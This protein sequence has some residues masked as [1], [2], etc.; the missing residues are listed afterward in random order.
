[1][2]FEFH[3]EEGIHDKIVKLYPKI[4]TARCY[5][6]K[7]DTPSVRPAVDTYNVDRDRVIC[8]LIN[9][10][11]TTKEAILVLC[12]SRLGDDAF[13]LARVALENSIVFSWL[14][15]KDY[16]RQ[17]VDYFAL[18]EASEIVRS[19]EVMRNHFPN[20][21]VTESESMAA[22]A[23]EIFE[24]KWLRWAKC[25]SNPKKTYT[26]KDMVEEVSK[27]D[28]LYEG[29]YFETSC[30]IHSSVP[31]CRSIIRALAN[32]DIC[33]LGV[34]SNTDKAADALGLSNLAVLAA[35]AAWDE[36]TQLELTDHLDALL[37]QYHPQGASL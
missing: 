16:W 22:I 9:K 33:D 20:A 19:C 4:A 35:L 8:A 25:P 30:Y 29:L 28:Y 6:R 21:S 14:L 26:F 13:A 17:R 32:S 27:D 31:S 12:K 18:Y 36:R 23:K 37:A 2:P 7:P 15:H 5:Y 11:V 1:M 24:G 34:R 10:L 3:K